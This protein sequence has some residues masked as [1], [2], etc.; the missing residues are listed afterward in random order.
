MTGVIEQA[1]RIF[2]GI[3]CAQPSPEFDERLAHPWSVRIKQ[4]DDVETDADQ[5]FGHQFGVGGGIGEAAHG[6]AAV[7]NHQ[8]NAGFGECGDNRQPK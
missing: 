8:R 6:V 1:H 2:A 5:R 4:L 3:L 7:T